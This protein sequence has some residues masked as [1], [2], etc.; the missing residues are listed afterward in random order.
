MKTITIHCFDKGSSASMSESI[1]VSDDAV[2]HRPV[3]KA[4]KERIQKRRDEI[5]A[6]VPFHKW[7]YE[8]ETFDDLTEEELA[9]LNELE[10]E[11]I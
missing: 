9:I 5:F 3:V 4:D 10:L 7:Y 8:V 2:G 6:N 1:L 11:V